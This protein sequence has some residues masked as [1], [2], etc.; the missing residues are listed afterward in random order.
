M[1]M[2]KELRETEPWSVKRAFLSTAT[3]LKAVKK[4]L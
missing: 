2:A 1:A 3:N 4:R